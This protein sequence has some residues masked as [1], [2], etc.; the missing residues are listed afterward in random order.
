MRHVLVRTRAA[1][2]SQGENSL[3]TY[4]PGGHNSS[5]RPS[6]GPEL[7]PTRAPRRARRAHVLNH[8]I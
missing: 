4:T 7:R 5:A 1:E 8:C 6:R 2:W 3:S